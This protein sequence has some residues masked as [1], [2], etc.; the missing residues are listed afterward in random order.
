MTAIAHRP[1]GDRQ[2]Q[3]RAAAAWLNA[4]APEA[5]DAIL[6]AADDACVGRVVLSGS[7]G[8]PCGVG[9]PPAWKEI[10][11]PDSHYG[12]DLNRMLHWPALLQAHLLSGD[13]RYARRA[14]AEALSWIAGCPRPQLPATRDEAV[15]SFYGVTAEAVPWHCLNSGIRLFETWRLLVETLAGTPALA[16]DE[17]ARIAGSMREQA[18]AIRAVSPTLFPD[19]HHNHY[20]MEMLGVLSWARLFPAMPDAADWARHAAGELERCARAQLTEDGAQVE[21]CPSYHNGCMAWFCLARQFAADCGAPLSSEAESRIRRGIRWAVCAARPCGEEV[22]WGD[23][24]P[25]RGFLGSALLGHLAFDDMEPLATAVRFAGAEAV[26]AACVNR[27]WD[28]SGID[29]LLAAVADAAFPARFPAWPRVVWQRGVKQVSLRT[30]WGADAASLFFACLTPVHY[31]NHGHIDPCGFDFTALGRPLLIDPGCAAYFAHETRRRIKSAAAHNTLTVNFREPFDYCSSFAFAPQ[32]E[33]RID[34]TLDQPG[35]LA[36]QA[37]HACFEPALHRRAVA[38]IGD[39]ILLVLDE[40]TDLF[41]LSSVQIY[42]QIPFATAVTRANG[43]GFHTAE[44][45]VNVAVAAS[46]GLVFSEAPVRTEADA[47]VGI[48]R[49]FTTVRFDD[50]GASR[51]TKRR[52][53]T[54]VCPVAAGADA[55]EADLGVP[56]ISTE[57]DDL[58][59]RFRVGAVA[60]TAR[61][62][63]D[64]LLLCP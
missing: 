52:Y 23:S 21:G 37:S 7:C 8:Q 63:A 53:A 35:L 54:V 31:G 28:V 58:T 22:P 10:R 4:H 29:R 32:K 43:C 61:W 36:A 5:C 2:S 42:F 17:L 57:T 38:V 34:W 44:E 60:Y 47:S 12:S 30:D 13:P 33:G 50:W 18:E 27:V 24:H 39:G 20:L 55:S 51:L 25:G 45:G 48:E 56:E 14:V 11:T 16:D 9:T 41:W 15:A 59:V 49:P 1:L 26:R 3:L 62:T 64:T 6:R 46:E 40:V 19:A